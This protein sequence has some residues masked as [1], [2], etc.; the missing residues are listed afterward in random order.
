MVENLDRYEREL[1]IRFMEKGLAKKLAS[2]YQH[3]N[4]LK[5]QVDAIR[6]QK[7]QF[8]RKVLQLAGQ[9]KFEAI[10]E[11]KQIGERQKNL[12]LELESLE[13]ECKELLYKF[14]I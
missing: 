1:E 2:V 12:E 4:Q 5:I 14:Q 11:M 7:N 9:A 6:G 8:N 13:T 10:E 3:K